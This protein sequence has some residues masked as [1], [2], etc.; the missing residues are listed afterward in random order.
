MASLVNKIQRIIQQSDFNLQLT[1]DTFSYNFL[2]NLLPE[3]IAYTSSSMR[4]SSLHLIVNDIIVNDKSSIIEFGSGISTLAIASL[5][6]K[7]GKGKCTTIEGSTEWANIISG[8]LEMNQLQSYV[9]IIVAP[10]VPYQGKIF[11]SWYEEHE[12][13]KKIENKRFDLVIIDGPEAYQEASKYNRYKALPFIMPY[14][15]DKFS[16]FLDDANRIGEKSIIEKWEKEY[17][18]SFRMFRNN[19]IAF[20]SR[21]NNFNFLPFELKQV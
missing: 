18:L 1:Q 14:L 10:I 9:N 17:N 19:S 4:M 3:N 8:I 11:S 12:I 20:A 2:K 6:S 15:T 13:N 5:L 21:G 7:N 16:V